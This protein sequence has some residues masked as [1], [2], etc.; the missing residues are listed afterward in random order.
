[1]NFEKEIEKFIITNCKDINSYK[2]KNTIKNMFDNYFNEI[3]KNKQFSGYEVRKTKLPRKLKKKCK[4]LKT[5]TFDFKLY[6]TLEKIN[7]T[8]NI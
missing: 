3:N 1:M 7:Y 2:F 8:I 5:I 6:M 4:Q